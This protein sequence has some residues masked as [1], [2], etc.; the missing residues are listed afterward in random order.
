VLRKKV[1]PLE[2]KIPIQIPKEIEP[3]T[4]I[5]SSILL[6]NACNPKFSKKAY[7]FAFLCMKVIGVLALS[8]VCC[9]Q[10]LYIAHKHKAAVRSWF[11][12]LPTIQQDVQLAEYDLLGFYEEHPVRRQRDIGQLP[13]ALHH[14]CGRRCTLHHH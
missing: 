2:V 1:A 10:F 6:L 12:P 4:Y 7:N 3:H 5:F 9:V 11:L 13:F 14:K 8:F